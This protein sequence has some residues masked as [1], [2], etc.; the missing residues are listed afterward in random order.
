MTLINK[1]I[2]FDDV[3]KIKGVGKKLANYLKK[4]KIEKN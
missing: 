4:K 2:I 3:S 1:N